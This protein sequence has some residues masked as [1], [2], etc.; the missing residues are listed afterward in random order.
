MQLCSPPRPR[1]VRLVRLRVFCLVFSI[2]VLIMLLR[3]IVV[4]L[5][6][7]GVARLRSL[8][9]HFFSYLL[10]LSLVLFILL[11]RVL[12]KLF[13]GILLALLCG[14]LL[15]LLCRFFSELTSLWIDLRLVW[16]R[17]G[18]MIQPLQT[19]G[20]GKQNASRLFN[21]R[22]FDPIKHPVSTCG[23]RD[24]RRLRI[25]VEHYNQECQ[26][27]C[28]SSQ[29]EPIKRREERLPFGVTVRPI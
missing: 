5:R 22:S 29:A 20:R 25:E 2:D 28:E 3:Q 13:G 21:V 1:Y 12:F 24:K 19:A 15:A 23:K 11:R 17:L 18:G 27:D 8:A 16:V 9:H 7:I 6:G 26:P 14:F 4:L 10:I